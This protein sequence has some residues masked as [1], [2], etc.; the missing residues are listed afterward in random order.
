MDQELIEVGFEK[1]FLKNCDSKRP[2]MLL[3][4]NHDSHNSLKVIEMAIGNQAIDLFLIF[5]K[6]KYCCVIASIMS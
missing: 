6:L 3:M 2:V 4:D 5:H 1:V